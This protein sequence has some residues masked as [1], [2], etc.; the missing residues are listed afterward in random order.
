MSYVR[1]TCL[2]VRRRQPQH[3]DSSVRAGRIVLMSPEIFCLQNNFFF[4]FAKNL[5]HAFHMPVTASFKDQEMPVTFPVHFVLQPHLGRQDIWL[6]VS[7]PPTPHWLPRKLGLLQVIFPAPLTPYTSSSHQARNCSFPPCLRLVLGRLW[8]PDACIW[9]CPLLLEKSLLYPKSKHQAWT[10][11]SVCLSRGLW[12]SPPHR[13]H[14]APVCAPV[15][16]LESLM[17]QWMGHVGGDRTALEERPR[18]LP[19]DGCMS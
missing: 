3:W 16:L 18:V 1:G 10:L 13:V 8:H 5:L 7:A 4:F 19:C 9:G 15:H 12:C 17:T 6:C 2:T 11:A 14:C